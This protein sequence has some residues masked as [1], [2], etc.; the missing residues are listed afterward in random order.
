MSQSKPLYL[1]VEE[2][3]KDFQSGVSRLKAQQ[4]ETESLIASG[5]QALENLVLQVARIEKMREQVEGDLRLLERFRE[6]IDGEMSEFRQQVLAEFNQHQEQTDSRVDN[7]KTDL[8][9]RRHELLGLIR[10]LR[11]QVKEL[12]EKVGGAKKNLEDLQGNEE[13]RDKALAGLRQ[14]VQT[15]LS[16]YEELNRR[17]VQGRR[18]NRYLLAAI[19]VMS[20]LVILS[21]LL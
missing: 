13:A 21:F 4:R 8:S 5:N 17:L 11:Q 16:C 18:W 6:Q 20:G 9:V 10:D 2:A 7:L 15:C 14:Q 19:A 1:Q 12:E 3:L